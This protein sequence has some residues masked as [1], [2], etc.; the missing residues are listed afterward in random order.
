MK[1]SCGIYAT[2]IISAHLLIIG[3]ALLVAQVFPTLFEKRLKSNIVLKNGSDVFK[4][5][6]NPPP[7]VY[8]QFFF[9]NVTNSEDILQG[10]KPSVTQVGPYTYREY[11]PRVNVTFLE[12]G[13]KVAALS[14]KTFVFQPD[15]SAGDPEIDQVTTV[16]IP[17]VTVMEL[18]KSSFTSLVIFFMMNVYGVEVFATH[19]VHELLWG[20]KD[21]LLSKLHYVKPEVDE[22]FGLMYKKNGTSDGDFVFKSGED[23][24]KDFGKIFTWNGQS[25]LKWWSSNES[26]MINGTD[27]S[28]FHPLISKDELLYIFAADLCRSI[29]IAFEK[30]VEVKGIPAYRFAPP[31]EVLA[32]PEKNPSNAGFCVP[33]GACLGAGVLKVSVCRNDAPVVVSFP[34]FFQADQKYIDAIEGMHPN[35]EDHETYLD[36]NPLTGFPVRGCKRAQLNIILDKYDAFP[37]TKLL[38]QT[39]FPIMFI[40]ESVIIDDKSAQNIRTLL[41]IA[42]IVTNFPLIIVG[43]GVLM[44]C[45]LIILLLRARQQKKATTRDDM[46]YTQVAEKQEENCKSNHKENSQSKMVSFISMTQIEH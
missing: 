9:F 5:W 29:Y 40:N 45:I 14:P 15:M 37:Q 33:S 11:R 10:K 18:T 21:P 26:N 1:R 32:A 2:G 42:T 3:I 34:H 36:V 6:E 39:I 23:D 7:P 43:L 41:L 16:N 46:V 44:L 20:F 25:T 31:S 13:T 24:Y 8:I 27:G 28:T 38:N 17:A 4:A 19:T 12:N 30:D 22:Y 35:K